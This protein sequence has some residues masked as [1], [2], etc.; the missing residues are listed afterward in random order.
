LLVRQGIF[1]PFGKKVLIFNEI[2]SRFLFP[3]IG[4]D[5]YGF[6][7]EDFLRLN[8]LVDKTVYIPP[9]L[10]QTSQLLSNK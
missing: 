2:D 9:T 6:V 5:K 1:F 10:L 8:A 4:T 3:Y 7:V